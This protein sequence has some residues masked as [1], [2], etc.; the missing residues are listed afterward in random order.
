MADIQAR[1][2][3]S[4]SLAVGHLRW[5]MLPHA[6]LRID[7]DIISLAVLG[8]DPRQTNVPVIIA[9]LSWMWSSYSASSLFRTFLMDLRQRGSPLGLQAEPRFKEDG[10]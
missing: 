8:F 6:R 7:S 5:Y 2:K 10:R 1:L 3:L 4:R 9:M